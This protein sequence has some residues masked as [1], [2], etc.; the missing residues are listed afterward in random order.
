MGTVMVFRTIKSQG[1]RLLHIAQTEPFQMTPSTYMCETYCGREMQGKVNEAEFLGDSVCKTCQ[2]SVKR[3]ESERAAAAEK[4][5]AYQAKVE[6]GRAT[7]LAAAYPETPVLSSPETLS[8][9]SHRSPGRLRH[10]RIRYE[11]AERRRR[12]KEI[13]NAL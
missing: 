13:V 3:I 2:A 4:E 5:N 6:Q 8:E 9:P 11:R 7:L 10:G 1:G 12:M